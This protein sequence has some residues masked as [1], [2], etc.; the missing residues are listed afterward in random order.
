MIKTPYYIDGH[1]LYME[2]TP[3]AREGAT[4]TLRTPYVTSNN[5]MMSLRF[6]Y[7]MNGPHPGDLI[8]KTREKGTNYHHWSTKLTESGKH[9]RHYIRQTSVD[10]V[11]LNLISQS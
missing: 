3:N 11:T 10:S 5:Q 6:S 9:A 1:Y 4:A 2:S 7:V 8:V